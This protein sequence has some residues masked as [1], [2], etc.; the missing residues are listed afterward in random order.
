M[1]ILK[2]LLFTF[3]YLKASYRNYIPVLLLILFSFF[4]AEYY[5]EKIDPDNIDPN[6]SILA[7]LLIFAL[8]KIITAPIEINVFRSILK[9]K[10]AENYYFYFYLEN[11]MKIINF[12]LLKSI[13]LY[14][15]IFLGL[16]ISSLFIIPFIS[17][18]QSE[19]V[20]GLISLLQ[21]FIILYIYARLVFV[22]PLS[23]LNKDNTF[24]YSYNLTKG[25]SVKICIYIFLYY[26]IS[27]IIVFLSFFL[28]T[29]FESIQLAYVLISASQIFSTILSSAV[30]ALICK[31]ILGN[32]DSTS[33]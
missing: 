15:I 8:L 3:Y 30:A 5:L 2:S 16:F 23:A 21:I 26:S 18:M 27:F 25:H 31:E 29:S 20:Q 4:N 13:F 6:K 11:N 12:Y 19:T 9:N 17:Y 1:L 24:T 33:D 7:I 32:L 14:S 28:S 10:P 22:L